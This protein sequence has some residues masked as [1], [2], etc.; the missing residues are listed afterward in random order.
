MLIIYLF[1]YQAEMQ[2]HFLSLLREKPSLFSDKLHQG[3]KL[4]QASCRILVHFVI[5]CEKAQPVANSL[6]TVNG[7]VFQHINWSLCLLTHRRPYGYRQ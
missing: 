3:G 2:L 1:C 4:I 7:T 5:G 6:A